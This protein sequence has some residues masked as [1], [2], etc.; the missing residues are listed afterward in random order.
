MAPQLPLSNGKE[1]GI[2][3][4]I[5]LISHAQTREKGL[6]IVQY[7]FKS[8]SC[9][10]RDSSEIVPN[11]VGQHCEKCSKTVSI[12]RRFFKFFRWFKHFEDIPAAKSEKNR[13]FAK[14]M[15]LDIANNFVADLSED[16][17]SVEKVGILPKGY[18]PKRW[19]YYANWT[20]FSLAILEILASFVK[21][22]RTWLLWKQDPSSSALR[23][24]TTLQALECL[25]FCSDIGK[26]VWDVELPFAK[27]SV[28][29][30][31]GLLSAVISTH[32]YAVGKLK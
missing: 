19:E 4:L 25:K 11:S 30:M 14:L 18:L 5:I 17:T 6:K 31:C 9:A 24:K 8:I 3:N 28:F 7:I 10:F 16:I 21:L 27:E 22:N 12:T 23:H 1:L 29:C 20:Q 26:A 15:F 32:K 13:I 2:S